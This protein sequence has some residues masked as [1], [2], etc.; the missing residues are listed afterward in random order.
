MSFDFGEI[1][2]AIVHFPITLVF[3]AFAFDVLFWK[4]KQRLFQSL[5]T[6]M[7]IVAGCILIPVIVSGV[8]ATDF[9]ADKDP[10]VFR[11][12]AFGIITASFIFGYA[13]FRG[14][15]LYYQQ[16]HSNYLFLFL[17]LV[18][19]FLVNITAEL[20]GVVVRGEGLFFHS[21]KPQGS[22][23]PYSHVDHHH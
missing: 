13:F 14:F 8:Y 12:Q 19:L 18:A 17:S 7:I 16:Q 11:H 2:P 10:D 3:I 23:L 9:Y 4:T 15:A 21:L 6:W 22:P 5:S 1:H 20:G